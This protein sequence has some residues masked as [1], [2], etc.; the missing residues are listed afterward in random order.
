MNYGTDDDN[1]DRLYR[2]EM[3]EKANRKDA[4]E[5]DDDDDEPED[6]EETPEE[7]QMNTIP[8]EDPE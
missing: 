2:F 4:D 8:N 7:N 3:E 6:Q 1:E 5:P